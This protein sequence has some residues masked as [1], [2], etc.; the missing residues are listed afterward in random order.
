MLRTQLWR[1]CTSIFMELEPRVAFRHLWMYGRYCTDVQCL[2]RQLGNYCNIS[3]GSANGNIVNYDTV[4][5][6]RPT[7]VWRQLLR[8]YLVFVRAARNVINRIKNKKLN[9]RSLICIIVPRVFCILY[10]V[11]LAQY[12]MKMEYGESERTMNWSNHRKCRHSKI[13]KKQKNGLARTCD[14]DGWRE[15]A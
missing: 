11:Q 15:N 2:Y 10:V 1:H 4:V 7:A 12:K 8:K 3:A 6:A 9:A 13:Y 5:V 14:A